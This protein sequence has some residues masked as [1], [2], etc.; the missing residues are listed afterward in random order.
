VLVYVGTYTRYGKSQGIY[1]LELDDAT[2]QLR[3]VHTVSGVSNPSYLT[4]SADGGVL[5][6]VNEDGQHGGVSAFRIDAASGDLTLLN[7]V[8][9]SGAGPA[10]LSLDPSGRWLIIGN[11]AGGNVVVLPVEPDGRLGEATQAI[12]HH[13]SGPNPRRQ[14]G[15]HPHMVA[16]DAQAGLVFIPDLGL[17]AVV[18]YR[19]DADTG[20]LAA[21]AGAGG[22]MPPGSGP[23]HMAFGG[24]G[25]HAYVLSELA[26][27]VVACSYDRSSG[28]MEPMQVASTLP[29]G[30]DASH[31]TCAAIVMA[32]SGRHLYASNR[33]HDSVA[34]FDVDGES[35]R[36]TALGQTATGGRTPRDFNVDPSGRYLLAANEATDSIVTFAVDVGSGRLEPTGHVADVPT[37]VRVLFART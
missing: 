2:G 21:D 26:S 19:F 3:P 37:P 31:T 6:A 32:P 33:G 17:D 8:S 30:Y 11:Y 16:I 22:R 28:D 12:A 24:D 29:D 27:N 13:G 18:G 4:M 25:R 35:G 14:E 9:S 23:R 15:P 5:C 7:R 1:V 36:L 10:H 34:V 20:R